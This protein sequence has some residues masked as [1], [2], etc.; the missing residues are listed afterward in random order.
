V[1]EYPAL[2]RRR[3]VCVIWMLLLLWVACSAA[4]F[5]LKLL[6]CMAAIG[7]IYYAVMWIRAMR[8]IDRWYDRDY[9]RARDP[10]GFGRRRMD[11]AP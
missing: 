3:L 2:N 6:A 8:A 4:V 1:T 9:D 10:L 5:G 7:F 11:R